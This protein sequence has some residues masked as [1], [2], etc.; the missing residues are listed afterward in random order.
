MA[1]SFMMSIVA[2]GLPYRNVSSHARFLSLDPVG[3]FHGSVVH[4]TGT[5][6][7]C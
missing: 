4:L 1:H 3:G 5:P 2:H 6:V 7:P